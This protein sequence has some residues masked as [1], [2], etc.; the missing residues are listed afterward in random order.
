MTGQL[1]T[2]GGPALSTISAA[3]TSAP[4]F[5]ADPITCEEFGYGLGPPSGILILKYRA[6]GQLQF[7][8]CRQDFIHQLYWSPDGVLSTEHGLDAQFIVPGEA[9]WAHRG[10]THDV[11]GGDWQTVYRIALR[12]VPEGLSDVRAGVVAIDSEAARLIE[13]ISTQAY[14]ERRALAARTQILSGLHAAPPPCEMRGPGRSGF[15][16]TVAR[17]L[18]RNPGDATRIDEWAR[19]LHIGVTTLQRD[20]VRDFGMPLSQWRTKY[21]L[22]VSRV[23]LESQPVTDVAHRVGYASPSA[24]VAAFAKEYGHTPGK[25]T[26]GDP[27]GRRPTDS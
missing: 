10:L 1:L 19:R 11:R 20:F 15:T 4:Q 25:L 13:E 3:A 21:R 17:E 18:M 23:L 5:G 6:A 14:D 8:Q 27:P 16:L 7:D 9:F 26:K 24:F 22:R 2:L 12:E